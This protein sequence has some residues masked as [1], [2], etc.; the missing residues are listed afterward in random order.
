MTFF[1][2]AMRLQICQQEP[3]ITPKELRA[4]RSVTTAKI[5]TQRP[6]RAK[7]V[8][9]ERETLRLRRLHRTVCFARLLRTSRK[10]GRTY[11]AARNKRKG[12]RKGATAGKGTASVQ[13]DGHTAAAAWRWQGALRLG[14][15]GPTSEGE[16]SRLRR[17]A[18]RSSTGPC[19]EET[20]PHHHT[21]ATD[22]PRAQVLKRGKGT[23]GATGDGSGKG[24]RFS[25]IKRRF[26]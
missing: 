1:L 7:T 20:R 11:T 5:H 21:R 6:G 26:L 8:A 15:K 9:R 24:G 18:W 2:A 13:R 4:S 3:K 10:T 19:E 14:R 12:L 17:P 23:R 25:L 16:G 22:Y